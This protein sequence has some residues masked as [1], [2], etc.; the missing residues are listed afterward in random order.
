MDRP[1][2]YTTTKYVPRVTVKLHTA[3]FP[4]ASV[5]AHSTVVVPI[6]KV[7]PEAVLHKMSGDVLTLSVAVGLGQNA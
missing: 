4:A 7:D 5:A 2:Q 3:E 6:G 1:Q